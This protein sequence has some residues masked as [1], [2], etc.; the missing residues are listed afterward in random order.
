M[1]KEI[2][3]KSQ[4]WVWLES[5]EEFSKKVDLEREEVFVHLKQ[6]LSTLFSF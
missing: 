3:F 5:L 6:K 2:V 4:C 1:L